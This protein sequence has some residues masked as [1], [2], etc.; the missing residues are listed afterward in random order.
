M[1]LTTFCNVLIRLD[2]RDVVD[3]DVCTG[4]VS[5]KSDGWETMLVGK[6]SISGYCSEER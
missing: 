5:E 1:R 4:T 6:L 3:R 2:T